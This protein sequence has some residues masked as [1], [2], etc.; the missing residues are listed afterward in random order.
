MAATPA[1]GTGDVLL[2]IDVQNDFCPGGRLAVPK[3][4]EVV[5]L[6]NRLARRFSHVVLTQDWHPE[7]HDSFATTH[8]GKKPFDVISL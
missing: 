5:P 4:D 6:V 2:V 7:R 8:P 3:G 1:I